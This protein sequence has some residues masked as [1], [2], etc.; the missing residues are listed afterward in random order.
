MQ[1]VNLSFES[2]LK[3]KGISPSSFKKASIKT[4]SHFKAQQEANAKEQKTR[5]CTELGSSFHAKI[6][7]PEIYKKEVGELSVQMFPTNYVATLAGYP[8]FTN[9]INKGI[10]DKFIANNPD[11][12]ILLPD[13]VDI[14]RKMA[15]NT[16]AMPGI[17]RILD[18]ANGFI[19]TSIKLFA[20]FNVRG[21]FVRFIDM[22]EEEYQKLPD[23]TK[24]LF[25][26]FKTRPDYF[27]NPENRYA[28]DLKASTTSDPELFP[29]EIETYGYHIQAACVLDVLSAIHG[30]DYDTFFFIVCENVEPYSPM[31]FPC[32]DKMI[33][34]ARDEYKEKL[35]WIKKAIDNNK[36]PSYEAFAE[37]QYTDDGIKIEDPLIPI[38][39]P[40]WYYRK[41]DERK[42]K[43]MNQQLNDMY[44]E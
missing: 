31:I 14:V 5:K 4:P 7:T 23:E 21:E 9:S 17:H 8:N 18:R 27:S 11:K 25:L 12:F 13:Q 20:E 43:L 6:L 34:Y 32:T 16:L 39:M 41:R 36:Y 26:R 10:K 3:E 28:A 44:H 24:G 1:I 2:Y 19:E 42:Y 38:D 37:P 40:A 22:P 35:S 33:E 30:V 15:T 29:K